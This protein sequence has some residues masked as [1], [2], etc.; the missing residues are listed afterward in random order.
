[1]TNRRN[2]IV[3]ETVIL[4]VEITEPDSIDLFDPDTVILSSLKRGTTSVPLAD[5]DF[6]KVATGTYRY[7]IDTTDFDPGTYTWLVVAEKTNLGVAMAEDYFILRAP[8]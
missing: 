4:K 6:T 8:S 2:W 7:T 3:G 1:M 5:Q